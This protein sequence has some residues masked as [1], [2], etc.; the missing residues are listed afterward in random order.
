[1]CS[2]DQSSRQSVN[3]SSL[4]AP[5]RVTGSLGTSRRLRQGNVLPGPCWPLETFIEHNRAF[6]A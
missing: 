4:F 3:R 5:M 1:M 2:D 6:V